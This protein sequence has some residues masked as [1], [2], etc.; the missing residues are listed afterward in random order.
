VKEPIN[1]TFEAHSFRDWMNMYL[2]DK[3][4]A[5]FGMNLAIGLPS[6]AIATSGQEMYLPNN[7]EKHLNRAK[8]GEKLLVAEQ[9]VLLQTMP[10]MPAPFNFITYLL[11]PQFIFLLVF[12]LVSQFTLYQ[13]RKNIKSFVFDRIF[14]GIVGLVGWILLL[15]WVAT[16]HG[17]T[18]WNLNLLWAVPF[19]LPIML[20]VGSQKQ[21]SWLKAYIGVCF[22][23]IVAL[24]IICIS[25]F[26]WRNSALI[27]IE[28]GF[29]VLAVGLRLSFLR[30]KIS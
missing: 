18:A 4:W 28:S 30:K 6:D 21:P 14:F 9:K 20:Y 11:S 2:G 25:G 12:V 22:W 15:L 29:L 10:I 23:L 13:F 3:P 8:L 26:V 5:K 16:D 17:V 7:L 27:P 1:G 19:H 24:I